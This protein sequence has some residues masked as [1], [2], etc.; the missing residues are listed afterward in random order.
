ML[1][2]LLR[3]LRS[4]SC[5]RLVLGF[6]FFEELVGHNIGSNV[7]LTLTYSRNKL[8]I[9]L[10]PSRHSGVGLVLIYI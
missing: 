9:I 3:L 10:F 5:S 6:F 7:T 2:F 1:R 8:P 4:L